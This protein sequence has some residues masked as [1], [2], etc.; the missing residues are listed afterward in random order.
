MER[1]IENNE[2]VFVIDV[3]HLIK[4]LWKRAWLIIMAGALCAA[5]AFAYT[6]YFIV[7]QYSA[8]ILLY[9]NNRSVSIGSTSVSIS[10]S[11]ISAAQ[12]LVD[13]YIVILNNRTTMTEVAERSG[14]DYNYAQLMGMV[15]ASGVEG[16]EIFKVKVTCDD[17]YEAA[18]IANCIADVLPERIADIIEGSSMRIVDSAVVNTG[19]VSPNITQKTTMGFLV[20]CMLS[21]MLVVLFYIL[22]DTIHNDEYITNNYDIPILARVPDLAADKSKHGYNKYYKYYRYSYKSYAGEDSKR[23]D[24]K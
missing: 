1:R 8:S 20:G 7:P 21:A 17:P 9:V 4:I 13:T 11:E 14:L 10:A 5:L 16:T 24:E 22:D 6:T 2:D 12:S 23:G 3:F 19:K 18:I 15:S